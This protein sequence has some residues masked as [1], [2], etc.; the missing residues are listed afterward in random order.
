MNTSAVWDVYKAKH[1]TAIIDLAQPGEH[2]SYKQK[3]TGSNP[4]VG[5]YSR[6]TS[7]LMSVLM[8]GAV[9]PSGVKNKV[10]H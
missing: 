3:V 2:L 5:I 7:L 4:V 6:R 1:R 9:E 8:V 10:S